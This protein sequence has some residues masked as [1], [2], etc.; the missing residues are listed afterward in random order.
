M[1]ART[2]S[3]PPPRPDGK[4]DGH[5]LGR[6]KFA[7][8]ADQVENT[9]LRG[10]LQPGAEQSIHHN[11]DLQPLA[12]FLR[13][14]A[15]RHHAV[16]AQALVVDLGVAFQLLRI[17]GQ[18]HHQSRDLAVQNPRQRQP[19]AAVV[20]LAAQDHDVFLIQRIEF[21][22]QR[23]VH[24]MRRVLHQRDAGNAVLFNGQPVHFAD[25]FCRQDNAHAGIPISTCSSFCKLRGSPM[26]IR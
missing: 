21:G 13:N 3:P 26:A 8:G 6:G 15:H 5:D 16:G 7:G 12:Q 19:V 20:A 17:A 23:L 1:S 2:H 9:A 4:I 22:H 18:H 11:I 25:F 24:A 14:L 10:T